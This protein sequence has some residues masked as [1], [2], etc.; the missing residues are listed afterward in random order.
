MR[1]ALHK[2]PVEE[3]RQRA[4]G[5]ARRTRKTLGAFKAKMVPAAIKDDR[6]WLVGGKSAAF[7]GPLVVALN[8]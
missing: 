2:N 6:R 7:F 3:P 4:R 8:P 1:V 5:N